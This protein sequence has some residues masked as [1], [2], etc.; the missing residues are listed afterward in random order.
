MHGI[1]LGLCGNI[2]L[3]D[4]V[5][6]AL[7]VTNRL[8][9]EG[10]GAELHNVRL[11]GERLNRSELRLKRFLLHVGLVTVLHPVN[12]VE[13]AKAAVQ[14]LAVDFVVRWAVCSP[15][16][17]L[18]VGGGGGE[19]VEICGEALEHGT[20]LTSLHV[21][22]ELGEHLLG[23]HSLEG[24]LELI[25]TKSA[26]R[27][28]DDAW[29]T[30]VHE[31]NE[32]LAVCCGLQ[33]WTASSRS[34]TSDGSNELLWSNILA[35]VVSVA[36]S[37]HIDTLARSG[38][39]EKLTLEGVLAAVC[40]VISGKQDDMVIVKTILLHDLVRVTSIRLVPVVVVAAGASD[41]DS[42]V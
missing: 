21:E 16:G 31:V 40:N 24:L 38:L 6:S 18:T 7:K 9:V 30:V 14:A 25:D 10:H 29:A 37:V 35:L 13:I 12:G 27:E 36:S 8:S 17:F 41:N 5:G 28:A 19:D 39:V 34:I 26:G 3:A 22:D 11:G 4:E 23:M 2:P 33:H 20:T 15:R 32:H 42:P 1:L